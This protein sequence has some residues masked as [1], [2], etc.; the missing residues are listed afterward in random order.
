MGI[1]RCRDGADTAGEGVYEHAPSWRGVDC[2]KAAAIRD[3]LGAGAWEARAMPPFLPTLPSRPRAASEKQMPR[4]SSQ[5][6]TRA[7]EY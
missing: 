6:R 2:H 3:A 5:V 1:S 7:A 4:T